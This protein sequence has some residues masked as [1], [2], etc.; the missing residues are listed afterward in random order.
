[1]K[2]HLLRTLLF[3]FTLALCTAAV[4]GCQSG[5]VVKVYNWG[6][7]IDES[8]FD[9]FEAETGIRVVYKTYGSNEEMYAKIKSGGAAYDVIIP[10]DYMIGR[11]IEEDMLQTLNFE[12]IPNA[13]KLSANMTGLAYDP[14]GAYSVPYM[15][16]TVG[17][18]Y[19]KTMVESEIDS[20]SALFDERFKNNILMFDNSRDA[21][22]IALQYLGYSVNTTDESEINEAY[23]LLVQQKPLVQAYV[24]DQIYNKMIGGEAAV[25]V[26]YAGDYLMM[27][28]E[29]SDLA[30]VHPKEGSNVFI[31]SMCIPV[32]AQ[33]KEN[34]EMFINFMLT[35][36]TMLR[37][38]DA[39]GYCVPTDDAY[40][41]LDE[42]I[43]NNPVAYPSEETLSKCQTF[44]N[45]PYETRTLY[46]SLWTKLKSK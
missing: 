25:G 39:T 1:M 38:A 34:A 28:E 5:P 8:I 46:D 30:F 24:M 14:E 37:N 40:A 36:A 15:W 23:E 26:Y 42:E 31:D 35:S 17:I 7:Y 6:Q 2:K 20:W 45:L 10:S 13:S 43:K 11:M 41:A 33:N 27:A 21:I 4:S 29:N 22:A 19:N 9:D 3:V 18:V 12:N 44:A 32:G 16:G